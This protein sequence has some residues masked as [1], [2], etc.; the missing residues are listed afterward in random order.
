MWNDSNPSV[1]RILPQER[2]RWHNTEWSPC[3]WALMPQARPAHDAATSAQSISGEETGM[4]PW[5]HQGV[6]EVTGWVMV[7]SYSQSS[8]S[9]CWIPVM[10]N[11]SLDS[12]RE[13]CVLSCWTSGEGWHPHPWS[14]CYKWIKEGGTFLFPSPLCSVSISCLGLG[15][16]GKH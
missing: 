11:T 1:T 9:S 2:F 7:S 13:C 5:E 14:T 16:C 4:R 15:H 12:Q 3:S 8:A 6:G 10:C